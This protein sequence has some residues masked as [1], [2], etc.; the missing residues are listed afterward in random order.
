M[1]SSTNDSDTKNIKEMVALI[2][3]EIAEHK[4]K[5]EETKKSIWDDQK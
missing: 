4:K 1:G 3:K 5:E 2:E